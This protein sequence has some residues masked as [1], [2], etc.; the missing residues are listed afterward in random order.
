[1]KAIRVYATAERPT[2]GSLVTSASSPFAPTTYGCSDFRG[3][4]RGNPMPDCVVREVGHRL[5]ESQDVDPA[6]CGARE[7]LLSESTRGGT[8][9]T[10]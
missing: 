7:H 5:P 2:P 4:R 8:P 10:G 3:Q 6:E 9:Y 1:V